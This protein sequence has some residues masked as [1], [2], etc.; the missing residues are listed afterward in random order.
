MSYGI[1]LPRTDTTPF[2]YG[3]RYVSALL[4]DAF[5]SAFYSSFHTIEFSW[6]FRRGIAVMDPFEFRY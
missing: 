1:R 4:F 6:Q 5:S 2:R 3:I